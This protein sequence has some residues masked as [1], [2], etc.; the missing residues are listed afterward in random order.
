MSEWVGEW[1]YGWIARWTGGWMDDRWKMD[2]QM[3]E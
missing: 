1:M 3:D 2:E